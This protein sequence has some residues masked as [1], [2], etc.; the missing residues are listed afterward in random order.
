MYWAVPDKEG[1]PLVGLKGG[2]EGERLPAGLQLSLGE[3]VHKLV[4]A[5]VHGEFEVSACLGISGDAFINRNT[6]QVQFQ[7]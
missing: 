5:G 1:E 7:S 2:V 6:L 3:R 4:P